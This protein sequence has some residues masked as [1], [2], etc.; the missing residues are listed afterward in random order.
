M[1]SKLFNEV[2]K[3][4]N[5]MVN[6]LSNLIRIKALAPENGGE[7][8]IDK[9]EYILSL[10]TEFDVKRYNSRDKRA[11]NG[12]RPNI[13]VKYKGE[14]KRKLWI[15]T[16]MD[17]VPA[18]N[19][20]LWSTPPFEPV[21]RNGKIFGRGAEDNGQSLV[22]SLFAL[23]VISRLDLIPKYTFCL[24][25][26]SDEETGSKHGILHLLN[27][28]VFKKDDLILVPDAGCK[29]G[30]KIEIA[31]KSILWLKFKVLGKQGH[32]SRPDLSLNAFRKAMN[33]L[34]ELD[35]NLHAKFN[36]KNELFV[37]P[38]STFEPTKKEKNV[39]NINTIPG[40][41]I[42]YM[43]CRILPEYSV[44]EVLSF[45][46]SFAE[47]YGDIEVEVVQRHESPPTSEDSEI[48]RILRKSLRVVRNINATVYGIGGNTCA[49]FFRRAGIA[50]AVW[51]TVD[52]TAH[53]PN[54]Y[55]LIKNMIE[56]SK[57]FA[58]LPFC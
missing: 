5:D 23:K 3:H 42:S 53:K 10:L 47:K 25:F 36:L 33:F 19:I 54:E 13:V 30:D 35:K 37:P 52:G 39:E 14:S 15:V 58:F 50:T 11:K 44:D 56:D 7:G 27:K 45:I 38:Y 9:A 43:D 31:E 1:L 26:V 20:S 41:D 24:A 51:S 29:K 40:I 6:V 16:H 46:T 8:E 32:S 49:A 22:A 18:G 28:G 48:V 21:I 4:K 55:A 2:E 34:T 57:V 17:V 12:I